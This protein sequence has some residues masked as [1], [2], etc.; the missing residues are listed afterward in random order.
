MQ[1]YVKI[2]VNGLHFHEKKPNSLETFYVNNSDN[3]M[4]VP[5]T[6][7]MYFFRILSL[8]QLFNMVV[9]WTSLV[10]STFPDYYPILFVPHN[11]ILRKKQ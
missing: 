7:L 11:N 2:N 4:V 8:I 1:T 5:W 6:S 9:P 10:F 3:N